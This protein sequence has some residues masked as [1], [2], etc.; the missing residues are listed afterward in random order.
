MY[1]QTMAYKE[2]KDKLH[3]KIQNIENL[4]TGLK[5]NY[6]VL[7][8]G[9]EDNLIAKQWKRKKPKLANNEFL[10]SWK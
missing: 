6:L 8:A 4:P 3:N 10:I 2:W 9:L 5:C 1:P 7:V